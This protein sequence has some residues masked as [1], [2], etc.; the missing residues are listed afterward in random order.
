VRAAELEAVAV[1]V[2]FIVVSHGNLLPLVA[3]RAFADEVVNIL[4]L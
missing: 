4:R 3:R 2:F 1:V